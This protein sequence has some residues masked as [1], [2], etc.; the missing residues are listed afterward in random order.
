MEA[1][2]LSHFED[3]E[4]VKKSRAQNQGSVSVSYKERLE[5][6]KKSLTKEMTFADKLDMNDP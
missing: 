1:D 4:E 3:V 2:T 5:A 6:Y